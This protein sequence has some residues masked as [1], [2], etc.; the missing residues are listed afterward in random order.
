MGRRNS[1]GGSLVHTSTW[2]LAGHRARWRY[3]KDAVEPTLKPLWKAF[4]LATMLLAG[5]ASYSGWGL[6]PGVSTG[7]DVRRIMGEPV[8][9]CPL[10]EGMQNWIYPR[11][12]SGLHTFNAHIDRSGVLRSIENVLEESGFAKVVKGRTVKD[13]V[14]CIFG[15][16]IY[17]TYFRAR[18]E[19]VWD[20]R[21]MDAWGYK[22]RYHVLFNDAGIVT[23]T[24]QI[25]EETPGTN[26]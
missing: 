16:P 22:T 7:A 20:Y 19:L 8:K 11:G 17:E 1:L 26:R 5:C 15:P 10:A 21:F 23:T 2:V 12:P 4:P 13:E 14:L 9:T 24:L 3:R 18:N 25:R 6:Q